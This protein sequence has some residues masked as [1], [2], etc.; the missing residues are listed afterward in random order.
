MGSDVQ[1]Q[2]IDAVEAKLWEIQHEVHS[3]LELSSYANKSPIAV[4]D[5]LVSVVEE[6]LTVSQQKSVRDTLM[7]IRNDELLRCLLNV[8]IY[9]GTIDKPEKF[10]AELQKFNQNQG[11]K[12]G[13]QNSVST[14]HSLESTK[15]M[16]N[17]NQ[18]RMQQYM[19]NM[20]NVS[21][22]TT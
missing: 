21:L 18:K 4:F 13:R 16:D 8:S 2:I 15:S 9:L 22:L 20:Q 11:D 7:K 1:K 19:S 3:E 10:I 14:S 12:T 5:H 6:H 17:N